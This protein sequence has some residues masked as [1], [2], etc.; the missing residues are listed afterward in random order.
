MP[1]YEPRKPKFM[2]QASLTRLTSCSVVNFSINPTKKFLITS[3]IFNTF[4]IFDY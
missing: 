4:S 2:M 3:D 1:V